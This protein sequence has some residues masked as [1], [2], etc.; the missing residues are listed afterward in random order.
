VK[1]GW[2]PQAK[3]KSFGRG[4]GKGSSTLHWDIGVL[5]QLSM[6]K[7]LKKTGY[8]NEQI[9]KILKGEDHE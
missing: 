3:L 6:I 2:I 5:T 9:S 1:N 7:A 4:T 8:K